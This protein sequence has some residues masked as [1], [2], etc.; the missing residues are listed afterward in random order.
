MRGAHEGIKPGVKRSRTPGTRPINDQARGSGRQP[1]VVTAVGR[2][3][4]LNDFLTMFPGLTPRALCFR[5]LCA[6]SIQV[7]QAH[8][9]HLNGFQLQ[10]RH[11]VKESSS[12]EP[13]PM[14]FTN[15]QLS[16][17][18]LQCLHQ[19]SGSAQRRTGEPRQAGNGAT[20]ARFACVAGK[21]GV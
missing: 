3:A 6:L 11:G 13:V 20:V 19:T 17:G 18:N 8:E 9:S 14:C 12:N 16:E 15:R 2:F 21:S 1:P 4:G 5:A 7:S 10:A